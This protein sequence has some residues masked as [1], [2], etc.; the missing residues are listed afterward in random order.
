MSLINFNTF[1]SLCRVQGI[2]FQSI[3]TFVH[4]SGGFLNESIEALINLILFLILTLYALIFIRREVEIDFADIASLVILA[5]SFAN[6]LVHY[7]YRV[8]IPIQTRR[9]SSWRSSLLSFYSVA[10]VSSFS[11]LLDFIVSLILR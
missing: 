3:S 8:K 1:F 4:H 11:Q 10:E 9:L 7:S 2:D 5:A 6:R